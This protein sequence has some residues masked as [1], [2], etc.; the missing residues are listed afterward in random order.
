MVD[1]RPVFPLSCY[2]P[3]KEEPNLIIEQDES[4]EEL[5]MKFIQANASGNPQQYVSYLS[6]YFI[7]FTK[8]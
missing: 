5:R 6:D 3:A 2:G 1:E 8:K 4:S 7:I